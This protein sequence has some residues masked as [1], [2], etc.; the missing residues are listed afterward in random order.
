MVA[1]RDSRVARQAEL[2]L[3]GRKARVLPFKQTLDAARIIT[4]LNQVH[5]GVSILIHS[6]G[7]FAIFSRNHQFDLKH[8]CGVPILQLYCRA[9][10]QLRVSQGETDSIRIS[11]VRQRFGALMPWI[12]ACPLS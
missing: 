5:Q 4:S 3:R 8:V 10:R 9:T 6:S 1:Y 11:S 12:L 2:A 7:R